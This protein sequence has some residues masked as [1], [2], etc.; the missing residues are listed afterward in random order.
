M[1]N[2]EQ[3]YIELLR[4]V[5]VNI[6]PLDTMHAGNTSHYL[7]VGLSAIHCI[8]EVLSNISQE[9]KIVTILDFPSGHG[10]VLRFLVHRFPQAQI[11]A[12]E[13][14]KRAVDYCIKH[15]GVDGAYSQHDLKNLS[16]GR[17]YNLIWCGSLIT[18]MNA[19]AISDLLEFFYR[20][21][22]PNGILIF[23]THGSFWAER[24]KENPFDL[25]V[26]RGDAPGLLSSFQQSGFAYM[27]YP[28]KD[29][30]YGISL[31][32]PD[33]IKGQLAKFNDFQIIYFGEHK[34]DNFQDIYGVIKAN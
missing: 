2:C 20:H 34:W 15:F 23:T 17:P 28:W 11:T 32:S 22:A 19:S 10:R 8:D 9:S 16:L 4:N 6:S 1:H 12:S 7:N 25:K 21:S 24:I 13:I 30:N 31:T 27:D 18:H 29:P 3:N 14:D 5:S 33:W 26:P